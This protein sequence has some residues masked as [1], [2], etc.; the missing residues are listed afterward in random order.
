MT[1]LGLTRDL[2]PVLAVPNC[3]VTRKVTHDVS[4]NITKL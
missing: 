2:I 1:L 4:E 3:H